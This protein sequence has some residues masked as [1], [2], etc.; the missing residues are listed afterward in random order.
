MGYTACTTYETTFDALPASS[1]NVLNQTASIQYTQS[2]AY[3]YGLWPSST[4]DVNGQVTSMAYDGLGRTLSTTLP[5]E[6]SGLTTTQMAYSPI[7]TCTTTG[8][9]APC[10]EVD[11][12][13]RLDSSHTITVRHFYDGWGHEVET[14]RPAFGD[15][16]DIIQF[17]QFDVMGRVSYQSI[18]YYVDPYTGSQ[19][20]NPAYSNPDTNQTGTAY[21]YDG[22][23][24][25]LS[26][27]DPTSAVTTTS[28]I[29][30]CVSGTC[31]EVTLVKDANSNQQNAGGNESDT[32]A[33][34][35]GRVIQSHDYDSSHILYRT[36]A[37]GYD[38]LGRRISTTYADGSHT[39]NVTYDLLGR[40]TAVSDPDLGNW[41]YSYDPNGNETSS[42]DPR[43]LSGTIY[44]GYDGLN[45]HIWTSTSSDGSSPLA[46]YT[47]DT[48]T[49]GIGRLS[50]ELFASGPSQSVT[51]SYSYSYDVR[52]RLTQ[53]KIT[54]AGASQTFGFGYNDA[55]QQTTLTYGDGSLLTTTYD[56]FDWLHG[57]SLNQSGTNT[58]LL[59]TIDYSSW[60]GPMGVPDAAYF[61][62]DTYTWR[63]A[64]DVDGRQM[65]S[66]IDTANTQLPLDYEFLSRDAVGNV[67]QRLTQLPAGSVTE[68]YCYDQVYHLTWA[69]S[70]ETVPT[71][72]NGGTGGTVSTTIGAYGQAYAFDTLDRLT[73]GP[74]GSYTYGDSNH[75][76]AATST[77]NGFSASYD[78]AGEEICRAP[79][80]STTCSGTPT[81][82]SLT[83]D[84]LNR[85]IAWQ[86]APS[87]PTSTAYDA[88]DGEGH[89][90]WQQ[91]SNGGTT[92]TTSYYC[93]SI[94]VPSKLLNTS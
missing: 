69:G 59:D 30:V 27:K 42:V 91:T 65:N 2:Q 12:T 9:N 35:L 68:Y 21:T 11:T 94:R 8:P 10:L 61:G 57:V 72:C 25:V 5:G 1:I 34:A 85:M 55:D 17:T 86:N 54:I 77:S 70:Q 50:G 13:Q 67:I 58:S 14:R 56:N 93:G 80:S 18:P 90:I 78:A 32:Y 83:Y 53:N 79:T 28:Y 76:D 19:M 82:Q 84:A 49:N 64:Y 63:T 43:G 41:T 15:L 48:G 47:Y 37:Y 51:G 40:Q 33:D 75:L 87:N 62:A 71:P 74:N 46:N 39:A 92:T 66:K 36:Y 24:R 81:G 6:G 73:T 45:R 52:G 89:R 29:P 4:T 44:L 20:G 38:Y 60:P 26:V 16:K 31:Y 88:Y 7:T 23:G 22:L 3:G